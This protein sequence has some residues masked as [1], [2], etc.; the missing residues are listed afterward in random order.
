MKK[1]MQ[2]KEEYHKYLQRVQKFK[3]MSKLKRKSEVGK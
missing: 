1:G 3:K 2:D